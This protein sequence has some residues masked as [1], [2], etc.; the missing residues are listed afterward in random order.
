MNGDM[1]GEVQAS[2]VQQ[3]PATDEPAYPSSFAQIAALIASGAPIP[4]IK[5]VPDKL[6]DEPPSE[7]TLAK[8]G[9]LK[10]WQR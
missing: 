1:N 7:P 10:P 3:Q 4:G 9:R 2:R 8:E 5:Q 6:N